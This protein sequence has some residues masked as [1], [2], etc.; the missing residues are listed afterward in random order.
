MWKK[1][2]CSTWLYRSED[3]VTHAL[4]LKQKKRHIKV[5]NLSHWYTV[6]CA[7]GTGVEPLLDV[8]HCMQPLPKRSE[9]DRT[10]QRQRYCTQGQCTVV[11]AVV[12]RSEVPALQHEADD[13]H[14][15]RKLQDLCPATCPAQRAQ[16]W[17]Y[18]APTCWAKH[19]KAIE[20][21]AR[22]L[23]TAET[24]HHHNGRGHR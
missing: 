9:G 22:P 17:S 4:K 1:P 10:L 2:I 11:V 14:I 16:A 15:G 5:Q 21:V 13:R 20:A 7:K 23:H 19:A 18:A 3:M 6:T 8:G 12:V 24:T